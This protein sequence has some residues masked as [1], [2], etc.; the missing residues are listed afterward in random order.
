MAQMNDE[1]CPA[2]Y[3]DDVPVKGMDIVFQTVNGVK[4]SDSCGEFK[5]VCGP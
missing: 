5:Y 1:S 2:G 4:S 3:G